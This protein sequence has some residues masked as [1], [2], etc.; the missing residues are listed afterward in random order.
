[1]R[2]RCVSRSMWFLLKKILTGFNVSRSS[3]PYLLVG[4]PL[5]DV[6]CSLNI[7]GITRHSVALHI[8]SKCCAVRTVDNDIACTSFEELT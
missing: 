4:G 7:R 1:M 5:K 6:M 3:S 8:L 2:Y